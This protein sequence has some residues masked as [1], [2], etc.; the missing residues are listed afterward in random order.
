MANT[1]TEIC[2][3][4]LSR[5]GGGRLNDFATDDSEAA[6]RCRDNY[7]FAR[8]AVLR[9]GYWNCATKRA[10]LNAAG[11]PP[12]WGYTHAFDFPSGNDEKLPWCLRVVE[13]EGERDAR[14][15]AGKW[16]V[17]GRQIVS[18]MPG[19]LPIIY[20]ARIEN[21]TLYDAN[22]GDCIA[23][24]LASQLGYP[25]TGNQNIER[26]KWEVYGGMIR[27]AKQI[28]AQEGI[29]DAFGADTSEVEDFGWLESRR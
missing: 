9:S 24:R 16:K 27:E 18:N 12:A 13:I 17:E 1:I 4:A 2:N 22:L 28:D 6:R 20:I 25:T 10:K 15:W 29:P 5:I 8:D 19:P 11:T 14:R 21:V 3:A 23:Q 7:P 26:F